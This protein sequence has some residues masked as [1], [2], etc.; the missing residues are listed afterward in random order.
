MAGRSSV[1]DDSRHSSI[2]RT[3]APP[4]TSP[5]S[6]F[7]TDGTA[8]SRSGASKGS[9]LRSTPYTRLKMRVFAPMPS[10]SVRTAV[11]AKPGARTSP[12]TANRNRRT[13]LYLAAVAVALGMP[14]RPTSTPRRWLRQVEALWPSGTSM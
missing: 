3:D 6:V 4:G 5:A 14:N 7:L 9:G 10:A 1:F 13:C 11:N 2:A 12:F 8:T